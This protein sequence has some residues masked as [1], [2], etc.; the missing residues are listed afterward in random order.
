MG[1]YKDE[2][3]I[4]TGGAGSVGQLGENV[5]SVVPLLISDL[6][7]QSRH[8]HSYPARKALRVQSYH[9]HSLCSQQIL[10]RGRRSN[11]C[12]RLP[13]HTVL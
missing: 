1:K 9:Y 7:Q 6:N 8:I 3:I 12:Y 10:L 5:S 2:P 4:V 13:R 11:P